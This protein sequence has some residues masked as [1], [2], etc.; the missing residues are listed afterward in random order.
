MNTITRVA[1]TVAVLCALA[2]SG[3]QGPDAK[4]KQFVALRYLQ[5]AEAHLFGTP[6]HSATATA[7]LDRALELLP[8]DE[9][10]RQ[11]AAP[12]YVL[13]GAYEQAL[14]LLE[15][16]VDADGRYRVMLAQCLLA[17]GQT[18]RGVKILRG[19]LEEAGRRRK[20]QEISAGEFTLAMNDA[21]YV[22]A[23]AGHELER[24]EKAIEAAVQL[25]RLQ[26]SFIDSLG[27][28][29]L[30]RGEPREAAFYL[31]QALR[32]S[33][34]PDPEMLY[35]L[36]VAYTQLGRLKDARRALTRALEMDPDNAKIEMTRRRLGRTLAPP[37]VA[38]GN[39]HAHKRGRST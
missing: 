19:M 17:T 34:G 30:R 8:D 2:L 18:Q 27:W 5:S 12:L 38:C 3:C 9:G 37:T 33:P 26:P 28:V 6:R 20:A 13:A 36:G 16:S 31:E 32:L 29:K 1:A 24:A 39:D 4:R 11:R 35:H 21:G 7:E 15:D 14:P 22:L 23:D 25:D 10:L